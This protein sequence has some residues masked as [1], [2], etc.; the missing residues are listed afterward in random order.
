MCKWM[1]P[2]P[3]FNWNEVMSQVR[4]G[5]VHDGFDWYTDWHDELKC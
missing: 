5:V 1:P 3:L 4:N 2:D